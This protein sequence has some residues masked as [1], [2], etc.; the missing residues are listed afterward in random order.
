MTFGLSYFIVRTESVLN[1]EQN[2]NILKGFFSSSLLNSVEKH[3]K[4]FFHKNTEDYSSAGRTF[5]ISLSLIFANMF[6]SYDHP[7]NLSSSLINLK[8]RIAI[9]L[10]GDF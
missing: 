5:Y 9:V 6:S 3:T 4:I 1:N 7:L 8:R 2:K 10:P